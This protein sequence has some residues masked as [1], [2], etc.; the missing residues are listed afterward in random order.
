M[1]SNRAKKKLKTQVIPVRLSPG[2]LRIIKNAAKQE[3]Q[4]VSTF[5]RG[6]SIR[7]ANR[8]LTLAPSKSEPAGD[9]S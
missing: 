2:E 5:I 9:K 1:T 7:E 3:D 6:A 8:L 4:G